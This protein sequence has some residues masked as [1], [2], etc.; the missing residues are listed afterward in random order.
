MNSLLASFRAAALATL[1]LAVVTGCLYPLT[2]WAVARIAFPKSAA[3]SLVSDS[4]GA[5]RGSHLLSQNFTGNQYFHPRPSS[6]GSAGHDASSSGGSNLGPT[7]RKL[8]DLLQE[9]ITTYRSLNGLATNQPVPADAVT[10]SA[11]G[12]DPHISPRNAEIQAPRV[13][14]A[15]GVPTEKVLELVHR[16]TAGPDL[17][18]LGEPRVS[19]LDL[20]LALDTQPTVP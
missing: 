18:L 14:R 7:S 8:L 3:G 15:R 17:G 1:L 9:R 5:V 4:S 20:N 10:A 2:V 19:I 13:A 6:A 11:S 16:L 12:L